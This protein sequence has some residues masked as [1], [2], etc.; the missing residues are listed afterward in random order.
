MDVKG[1]VLYY[2]MYSVV[3]VSSELADQAWTSA[4]LDP[5]EGSTNTCMRQA[6]RATATRSKIVMFSMHVA[7]VYAS[8]AFALLLAYGPT[9]GPTIGSCETVH[10]TTG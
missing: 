7:V 1:F 4:C 10:E 9:G 2:G 3:H 5:E 8:Q 6:V